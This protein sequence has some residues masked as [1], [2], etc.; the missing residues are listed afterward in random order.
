MTII[1]FISAYLL[2]YYTTKQS[3]YFHNHIIKS[4][5]VVLLWA[6]I[7]SH[8]DICETTKITGT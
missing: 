2:V 1:I 3:I 4:K 7:M 6:K 8:I 5:E